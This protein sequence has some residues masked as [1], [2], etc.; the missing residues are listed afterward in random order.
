MSS[1]HGPY[2]PFGAPFNG[3]EGGAFS[4]SPSG[5]GQPPTDRAGGRTGGSEFGGKGRGSGAKRSSA[6]L[7]PLWWSMPFVIVALLA[8]VFLI[9]L[10]LCSYQAGR[11]Y[12]A[13]RF[14][15]ARQAYQGQLAWTSK[16]PET[17]VANYNLGTTLLVQGFVDVG[18]A[19]LEV[20]ME[21]VPRAKEIEPGRI[22][23]YSY[24]CR[25]RMNLALGIESQGDVA[26][27]ALEWSR[28]ADLYGR[29]S[30]LLSVCQ[31]PSSENQDP[32]S[33]QQS[34]DPQSGDPQSGDPQSGDGSGG[35]GGEPQDPN[36]PGQGAESAKD[37][38]DNKEQE[39]RGRQDGIEPSPQ[40]S[41]GESQGGSPSPSPG[42][43]ETG[44]GDPTPGPSA[45]PTP[46][47]FGNET[48]EQ[49]QRREELERR[50][51]EARKNQGDSYD[52][53]RPGYPSGGW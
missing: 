4:P 38:V 45:S 8:S 28:A 5:G 7:K 3:D 46:D 17:W 43:G 31:P 39:A 30:E 32:Q 18:V 10:H 9:T 48:D 47:P 13:D 40:P 11:S 35:S 34:G 41:Q 24:E 49:R 50:Q 21:G 6:S 52:Q 26:G 12:Q 29:A 44:S 14:Q 22:Q 1:D 15:G 16:G 2:M 36:D 19:H 27:Q 51:S 25:V 33:G 53:N 20:A 42:Q 37:R 23:T